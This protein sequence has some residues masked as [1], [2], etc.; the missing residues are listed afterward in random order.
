VLSLGFIIKSKHVTVVSDNNEYLSCRSEPDVL[1]VVV[2]K[3]DV[4]D[5]FI[6]TLPVC[7]DCSD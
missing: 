6:V 1:V 7:L 3:S 5:N 4:S 2:V